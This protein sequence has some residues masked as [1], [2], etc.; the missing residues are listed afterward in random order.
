MSPRCEVCDETN[1][2]CHTVTGDQVREYDDSGNFVRVKHDATK[3][4]SVACDNCGSSKVMFDKP[5]DDTEPTL[6]A[7][8]DE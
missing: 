1:R 8:D 4:I 5:L 3:T 6:E 2:F 7:C